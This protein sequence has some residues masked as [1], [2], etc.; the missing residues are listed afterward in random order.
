MSTKF[1]TAGLANLSSDMSW[2]VWGS[3]G[4]V[5]WREGR[6]PPF[7]DSCLLEGSI[8]KDSPPSPGSA[9]WFRIQPFIGFPFS[10]ISVSPCVS[11]SEHGIQRVEYLNYDEVYFI[12]HFFCLIRSS[13]FTAS[14][15]RLF[16]GFSCRNVIVLDALLRRVCCCMVILIYGTTYTYML[17]WFKTKILFIL[18]WITFA[19]VSNVSKLNWAVF[20]NFWTF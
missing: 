14:H 20:A 12:K 1:I 19:N 10:D 17:N 3:L 13:F 2:W 5:E 8:W 18:Y 7:L 4:P 9:S 16:S 11:V 15:K 6:C